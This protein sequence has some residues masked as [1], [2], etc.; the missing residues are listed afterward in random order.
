MSKK[1]NNTR[2][3]MDEHINKTVR[4][5]EKR[6]YKFDFIIPFFGKGR[7]VNALSKELLELGKQGRELIICSIRLD[8]IMRLPKWF[9]EMQKYKVEFI[10]VEHSGKKESIRDRAIVAE[11]HGK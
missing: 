4:H 10:F 8:R 5:F 9:E 6:G 3:K 11:K 1:S 7:K 2:E